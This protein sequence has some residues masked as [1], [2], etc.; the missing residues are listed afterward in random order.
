MA[1][2]SGVLS[3]ARTEGVTAEGVEATYSEHKQRRSGRKRSVSAAR[4]SAPSEP[5]RARPTLV[6]PMMVRHLC[7]NFSPKV[8]RS[9]L[10]LRSPVAPPP[11]RKR[12]PS[13][14]GSSLD[15]SD[16]DLNSSYDDLPEL[17]PIPGKSLE[18][19]DSLA[20]LAE[21]ALQHASQLWMP[22]N[23]PTAHAQT[24]DK[25]PAQSGAQAHTEK[26][27]S[28]ASVAVD[29]LNA[30]GGANDTKVSQATFKL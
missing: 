22:S 2:P 5:K 30:V 24:A 25:Q 7:E 19:G 29:D 15:S 1:S 17:T 26:S 28:T 4:R 6:S 21:A 11:A 20:M 23:D 16:A 3:A 14:V 10:R 12:R 9:G 8:L 18:R 27:K 13:S